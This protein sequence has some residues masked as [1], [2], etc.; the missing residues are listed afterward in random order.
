MSV[1]PLF[2]L[3]CQCL[4]K[5]HF[6]NISLFLSNQNIVDMNSNMIYY[7]KTVKWMLTNAFVDLLLQSWEPVLCVSV[8][9][10]FLWI[11]KELQMNLVILYLKLDNISNTFK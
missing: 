5:N 10:D 7:C 4:I 3:A 8:L 1:I 2:H 6:I 9:F 11:F